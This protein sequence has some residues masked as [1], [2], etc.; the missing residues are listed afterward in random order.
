VNGVLEWWFFAA[1]TLSS[2]PTQSLAEASH[3]A[4]LVAFGQFM[5]PDSQHAPSLCPQRAIDPLIPGKIPAEF[6]VPEPA[7]MAGP[8]A[9]LRAAVPET[10]V[11]KNRHPPCAEREIRFSEQSGMAAP[12]GEAMPPQNFRQRQLR[13]LVPGGSNARHHLRPLGFGE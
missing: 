2:L 6:P 7:V 10:A 1:M 13:L 9:M 3:Q 4:G 5:F 8:C 11:H 12:S